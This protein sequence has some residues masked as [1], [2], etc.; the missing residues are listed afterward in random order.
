MGNFGNARP[1]DGLIEALSDEDPSVRRTAVY[2][3]IELLSNVPTD[4]SHEIRETV[5]DKLSETDDASVVVPMIDILEES[6]QN[7]QRRNTAW[8]LGRVVG[9]DS[10]GYGRI[11][12]ALVETL[13]DEDQMTRQFA[14][15]SLAE[16]GGT[17]VET[18]LLNVLDDES[19]PTDVRAQAVFTL[20]K[21]GSER[22]RKRLDDLIDN[23]ESEQL[24]EKAFS[25]I[26]KLGGRSVE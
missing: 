2:S 15:T 19:R 21:V 18:R 6:T 14:A 25:A 26:S 12:R 8:L 16:I 20:G 7:R 24:R 17:Q 23:T 3:I 10:D 1:V 9:Q 11:V 13:E 22:S 4:Q 5:V